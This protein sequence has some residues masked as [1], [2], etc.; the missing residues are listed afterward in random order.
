MGDLKHRPSAIL[1]ATAMRKLLDG[2][3]VLA[4]ILI[5]FSLDAWWGDRADEKRTT[6]LL[7]ALE[8]EWAGDLSEMD[9]SLDEIDAYLE[10]LGLRINASQKDFE[11]IS[12]SEFELLWN[13]P[14]WDYFRPSTGA[15]QAIVAGGLAQVVDI[16]LVLA[17]T[18]WP[19]RLSELHDA[20]QWVEPIVSTRSQ[21]FYAKV[22][23]SHGVQFN[24]KTG[25][26][27]T[28][29]QQDQAINQAVFS[30]AERT[31]LWMEAFRS[32]RYYRD[33]LFEARGELQVRLDTLRS[34][35]EAQ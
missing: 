31:V 11:S 15:I 33:V 22:Y 18:S 3:A 27:I 9:K 17:I 20:Q 1:A 14:R 7:H 6:E 13:P 28:T 4:A 35:I 21:Q 2:M 34:A 29:P 23:Q 8:A 12:D 19:S 5:A 16:H 30:S 24:P 32:L 25:G 10:N 26:F